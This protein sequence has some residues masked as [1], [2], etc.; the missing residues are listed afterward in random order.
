LSARSRNR[1]DSTTRSFCAEL[2]ELD[3]DVKLATVELLD[4]LL[5]DDEEEKLLLLVSLAT[6]E[7]EL[8]EL[9]T[10]ATVELELLELV[11]LATV[12][13]LLDEVDGT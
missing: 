12:E 3:E 13:E 11:T 9:V 6:V 5:D 10:L 4:E 1:V 8:L 2:L 7:L